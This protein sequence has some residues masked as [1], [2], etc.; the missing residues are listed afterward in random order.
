MF[1]VFMTVFSGL[2]SAWESNSDT[3]E[4]EEIAEGGGVDVDKVI[5]NWRGMDR[6]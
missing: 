1:T 5:G 6:V 3:G 4:R 2:R